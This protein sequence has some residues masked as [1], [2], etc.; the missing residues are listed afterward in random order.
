MIITIGTRAW[1]CLENKFFF[2]VEKT[3]VVNNLNKFCIQIDL[4]ILFQ[5]L[6][7]IK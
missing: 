2:I 4:K 1:Y 3:R 6:K 7:N 5:K